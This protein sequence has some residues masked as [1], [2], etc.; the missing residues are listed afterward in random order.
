MTFELILADDGSLLAKADSPGKL[1]FSAAYPYM[2]WGVVV[3]HMALDGSATFTKCVARVDLNGAKDY[4]KAA[5]RAVRV[6]R[7]W[8]V[9]GH[10]TNDFDCRDYLGESQTINNRMLMVRF[11]KTDGNC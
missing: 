7:G 6:V 9:A 4:R 5:N 10:A 11:P 1:D 2:R 3:R 8:L